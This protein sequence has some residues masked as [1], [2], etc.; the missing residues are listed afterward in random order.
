MR[1]PEKRWGKLP[2]HSAGGYIYK[3]THNTNY[4][5]L[6]HI[7]KGKNIIIIGTSDRRSLGF[8]ILKLKL[9]YKIRF[10]FIVQY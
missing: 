2:F 9:D 4:S 3:I 7:M 6:D 10:H 5:Q 1:P 8:N